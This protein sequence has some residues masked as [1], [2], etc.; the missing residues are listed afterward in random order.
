MNKPKNESTLLLA[1]LTTPLALVADNIVSGFAIGTVTLLVTATIALSGK[2]LARLASAA[3]RQTILLIIAAT[4]AGVCDLLLRAFAGQIHAAIQPWLPL[5]AINGLLLLALRKQHRKNSG[6]HNF[7]TL[8]L[9]GFAAIPPLLIG[10]LREFTG[11]LFILLPAAIL[12]AV[13]LLIAAKNHWL[14]SVEY[15]DSESKNSRSRRVR[16]TGPIS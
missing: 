2:A 15:P 9:L 5:A 1:L 7:E 12:I 11:F 13:A 6:A 4:T 8:C 16:V 3:Q 14:T 10:G